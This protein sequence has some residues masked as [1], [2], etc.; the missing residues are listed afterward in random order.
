MSSREATGSARPRRGRGPRPKRLTRAEKRAETRRRLLDAA[1][2]VFIRRGFGGASVEEICAEAGYTR[3]AFYSNF[4]S[5]EQMFTELLHDRVYDGFRRLLE[6]Q[7]PELSALER[8][9]WGA[10]ELMELYGRDEDAWLFAL[11]LECLA[12]AARHPEFRALPATFWSGT[13]AM[14]ASWLE[15][16]VE[17]RGIRLPIDAKHLAT[18]MTALDIGLAVQHLVDPAEVPLDLYPQLYTLLFGPL[19]EPPAGRRRQ[20][21]R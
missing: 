15:R 18:A 1:A 16:D 12:H 17:Q 20:R 2:E 6:R 5:K 7:A 13:R 19:L 10:R 14:N 8:L 21:T 11:W 9:R 3:G 4:E